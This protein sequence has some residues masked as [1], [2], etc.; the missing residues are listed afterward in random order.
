M[1]GTVVPKINVILVLSKEN[2][3]CVKYT[4]SHIQ[5]LLLLFSAEVQVLFVTAARKSQQ[6]EL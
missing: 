1:L 2:S 5:L 4:Y 3:T 6:F